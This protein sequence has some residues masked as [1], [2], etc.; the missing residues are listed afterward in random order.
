VSAQLRSAEVAQRSRERERKRLEELQAKAAQRS[1]ASRESVLQALQAFIEAGLWFSD[2]FQKTQSRPV[3]MEQVKSAQAAVKAAIKPLTSHWQA[4]RK[5]R[6]AQGKASNQRRKVT[7]KLSAAIASK[8]DA[9]LQATASEKEHLEATEEEA[10]LRAERGAR[11]S[12]LGATEGAKAAVELEDADMKRR[13]DELK[14]AQPRAKEDLKIARL[15]EKE[16]LNERQALHTQCSR[17]EKEQMQLEEAKNTAVSTLKAEE[18][19]TGQDDSV[20]V[21]HGH[22]PLCARIMKRLCCVP[23]VVG[24]LG[25]GACDVQ[26]L[27]PASRDLARQVPM[28]PGANRLP[29]LRK[30]AASVSAATS[31]SSSCHLP[32]IGS[33]LESSCVDELAEE[34]IR[35]VGTAQAQFH[36]DRNSILLEFEAAR[37]QL[38]TEYSH[39]LLQADQELRSVLEERAARREPCGAS[40][41]DVLTLN[42]GGKLYT[43]KRETLLVCRGS[44]LA[45]L[46]SGKWE[47]ALQKDADGNPFL[48]IDPSIWDL[49]LS[50]L[51]DRKIEAADRPAAQPAV[52][53]EDLQ[54]FQA[55]V[56]YLGL[57][58]YLSVPG[59]SPD[60]WAASCGSTVPGG[61]EET[62]TI[63]EADEK[64][65]SRGFLKVAG[66]IF[67]AFRGSSSSSAPPP[68]PSAAPPSAAA[69]GREAEGGSAEDRPAAD[70]QGSEPH[71]GPEEAPAPKRIIGWSQ[72]CSHP[73]ARRGVGECIHVLSIASTRPKACAAAAR[74]TR[75]YQSGV[76]YFEVKVLSV[77]D[78]SYV[79]L[80]A[81]EWTST[82]QPVGRASHSWGIAS[83]GVV[84]AGNRELTR[85]PVIYGSGST[86]GLRLELDGGQRTATAYID[87]RCFENIFEDLAV[88]AEVGNISVKVH[89]SLQK[90]PAVSNMRAPAQYSLDC[91]A[92]PP[93][94]EDQADADP[95]DQEP[96]DFLSAAGLAVEA[97]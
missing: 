89:S 76:H 66:S 20:F 84:F 63:M 59:L 38:H 19:K 31:Y 79:G 94:P 23:P 49:I 6:E 56:D 86:I 67:S 44:F 28:R 26:Q 8:V 74:S 12:E 57:R 45:E 32:L 42:V 64:E 34:L 97:S 5:A 87:G 71:V 88:A 24:S 11:E 7:Q 14:A 91:D 60:G 13:R 47:H 83:S 39:R 3:K 82:S 62:T 17:R 48:D 77:S 72:K 65:S 73:D 40:Q 10:Q 50:W 93:E 58:P 29:H 52:P 35:T 61:S 81:A 96:Q 80:A 92:P 68:A 2:S 75:G 25:C 54:H 37:I 1:E 69:A 27:R 46:F 22:L 85:L 18:Y 21:S 53:K 95:V 78:H 90:Y 16:A 30:D 36:E 15:A 70:R 51:R 43:L 41:N 9:E 33:A 4:V 55:A